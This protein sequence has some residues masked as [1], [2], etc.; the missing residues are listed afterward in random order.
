ML[1]NRELKCRQW[2]QPL[3]EALLE[4]N[5]VRLRLKLQ[6]AE[7]AIANRLRQLSFGSFEHANPEETKTGGT[8]LAA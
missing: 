7:E 8:L 3:Y 4:F 1:L 2:Q 5:R 6:K